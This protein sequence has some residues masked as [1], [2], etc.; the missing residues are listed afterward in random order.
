LVD[1]I[2]AVKGV[3]QSMRAEFT[4]VQQMLEVFVGDF[5]MGCFLGVLWEFDWNLYI[6]LQ[7][8]GI[9]NGGLKNFLGM[10]PAKH[11]IC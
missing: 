7:V 3:W 1:Q 8:N 4:K 11:V 9:F 6:F 2:I 5:M 10:Q